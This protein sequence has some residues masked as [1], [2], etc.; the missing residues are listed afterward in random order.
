MIKSSALVVLFYSLLF[1]L[2]VQE[3][4][5]AT[6]YETLYINGDSMQTVSGSKMPYLAFN[7]S[8]TF[9]QQNAVL[10]INAG[11]SLDL[12]VVNNDSVAHEFDV[13][14]IAS[15]LV[16]IPASD[17][18]RIIAQFVTPGI[19]IYYDP[20]N[21]PSNCY[22]GLG[23]MIVVKNQNH[24][25]FYWNLKEH[26]SAWNN[27]LIT[28]GT[29]NWSTYYPE[30]F[31]LNGRSN[32]DINADASARITGNVG[33]TLILN[34]ANT[35]R[36]VHSIHF[37]GYH[38]EILYS[39]KDATHVGRSKDTFAMMPMESMIL[40]IVP[41]KPGEYPVHDHNLVAVTADENYPNGMF[42][43]ILINP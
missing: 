24:S 21:Y 18:T 32:P 10:E 28:G 26:T 38:A 4:K 42:S 17:S 6:V 9:V 20:L 14:G 7:S 3:V 5:S 8:I 13:N 11:D 31:T 43:T 15:V 35:G 30:Y 41:D 22:L 36:G 40:R 23:G 39:S 27:A 2:F 19:Y 1:S 33:D 16:Q 29:V 25:S 34:M 12:W 37:H